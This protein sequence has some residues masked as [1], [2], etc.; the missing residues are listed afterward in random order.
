MDPN[1]LIT[2]NSSGLGR[3]LTEQYL[4]HG[5]HV[6]GLSRR[7]CQGLAGRLHDIR[8]D[9]AHLERIPAALDRLLDG[10]GRLD[11]VFLN[12]GVLGEI[13]ELHE[14]AI[15]DIRQVMEINVWA[16]KVVLDWLLERGIEVGQIVLISS[17]AAVRGGKGW[18]AYALSKATLNMLTQLYAHEFPRSHLAAVAPGLVDTAMQ[19]YL[20]DDKTLDGERFPSLQRIRAA[21]GSKAMPQPG[22]AAARLIAHL[23]RIRD[24]VPSGAYVDIRKLATE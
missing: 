7:G 24:E 21:R 12:A 1:V 2:G 8:C 19:D 16:N 5:A 13:R 3:S 6:Y 15:Q 4:A 22:E 23:D 10:V 20:C 11:L 9:L 17:G 14:T 18:G